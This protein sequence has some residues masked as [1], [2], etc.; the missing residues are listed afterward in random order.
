MSSD[1]E[2]E[3]VAAAPED[4]LSEAESEAPRKIVRRPK[5]VVTE[6]SEE[7]AAEE[8]PKAV[9]SKI[10]EAKATETKDDMSESEMSSVID[11]SPVKKGRQKKSPPVKGAKTSKPKAAKPPAKPAKS[12]S[13]DD[14]DQAEIKRLQSWL[15]K[16]GIRKV[17]SSYLA[18][19]DTSK[20]KIKHLKEMLKDAGM[21]GK[22]SVEK[23]A[24][25]KEQREFAK[26]LEAI[27]E[28]EQSW[29]KAEAAGS[30][31]RPRRRAAMAAPRVV[32]ADLEDDDDEDGS[33]E[34]D[35]DDEGASASESDDGKSS[36]SDN[37]EDSE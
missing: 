6:D 24:K 4:P 10:P 22:Y 1:E 34:A 26:D 27:K 2:S 21:D 17:W 15:V 20:D 23:A 18:K 9:R 12:K 7:S 16:C 33:V 25:I 19:Y 13:E 35:D 11:E 36:A 14:P 32:I 31:G 28:G 30:G 29:G 3:A 5:K 8:A 37:E